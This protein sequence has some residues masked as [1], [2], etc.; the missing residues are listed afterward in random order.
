MADRRRGGVSPET[1]SFVIPTLDEIATIERTLRC[2]SQY[3]GAREIIVSDGNSTDGTIEVCRRYADEVIVYDGQAR[4]TIGMARN[5]GAARARGH[6]VVFLDADVI[7]HDVDA[8]F[9]RARAEFIRRPRLVALTGRYRV[10]REVST[11][12]D[13]Y[14]FFTLGL[15]FALQNNVLGVGG[16]GGEFQ[17]IDRRAFDRVDGFDE[18][19]TASEDMDLFRRLSKIGQTRFVNHLT[20]WHT[21]RRAHAVGWPR[22]LWAWFS[23][24]VSVF[25][26]RK[27][28]SREWTPVR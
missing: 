15:Q 21:G 2:L 4:Q 19:L 8:F 25:L 7:I 24:S 10:F 22:L 6:F 17:M 5:M 14:V 1:I 23:N 28:A 16:S 18:R 20:V 12:F 3:S 27:S 11:L 9:A 13:R 26:F